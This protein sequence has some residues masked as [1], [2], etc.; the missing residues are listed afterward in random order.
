MGYRSEVGLALLENDYNELIK[1]A[2]PLLEIYGDCAILSVEPKHYDRGYG[3]KYVYLYWS[4]IKWYQNF[5]E[6]DLVED[7][8]KT[9]P[10]SFLRIGEDIDDV[11]LDIND[12]GIYDFFWNIQYLKR[13]VCL[14]KC[15]DDGM[16]DDF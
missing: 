11:V 13:K 2:K 16:P 14:W 6:V 12:D 15:P 7:F 5:E 4:S 9:H 10:H 1:L 8:I 3:N